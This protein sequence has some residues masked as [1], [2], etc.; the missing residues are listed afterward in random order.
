MSASVPGL[1]F[2]IKRP[3]VKS[4]YKISCTSVSKRVRVQNFS[5]EIEFDLNVNVL[6]D[7]KRIFLMMVSREDS[8]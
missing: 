5:S 1:S 6:I 4:W 8:F 3:V 7:P 2:R